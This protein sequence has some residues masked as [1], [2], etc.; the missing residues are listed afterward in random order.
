ML[1]LPCETP[2]AQPHTR[3]SIRL[4]TGYVWGRTRL[5]ARRPCQPQNGTTPSAVRVSASS[6]NF[7]CLSSAAL[8]SA[9]TLR[10]ISRH[11]LVTTRTATLRAS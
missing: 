8:G 10:L 9:I 3:A 5:H 1:G 11:S 7:C 2:N 6:S 4:A